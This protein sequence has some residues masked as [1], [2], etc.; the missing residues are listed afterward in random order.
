M[1]EDFAVADGDARLALRET[2][3]PA[4]AGLEQPGLRVK[5]AMTNSVHVLKAV[6]PVKSAMTLL[7]I[8]D[9][10]RDP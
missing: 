10:I 6:M 8:P 2:K 1:P 5:P 9:L 4:E 3:K 7:V